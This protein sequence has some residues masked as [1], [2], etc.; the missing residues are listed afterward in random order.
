MDTKEVYTIG[1]VLEQG[2]K[3]LKESNNCSYILDSQLLLSKIINKDKLFI[4]LNRD[5]QIS[6]EEAK[7]YF[8]LIKFRKNKMPIKYILGYTEFMGLN[9]KVKQGVLI[10][11]PDTEIL[12]ENVISVINKNKYMNIADV[13]CGSGAIGVSIAVYCPKTHIDCFDISN[14]ACEV[15]DENASVQ[16]AKHR[17]KVYKS[18][19][20]EVA[21]KNGSMYDVIVS[22]PP[23]IRKDVIPSLMGD[24][25]DYEPHE[26]LDGGE[27]GLYFYRRIA[28]E[29]QGVLNSNGLIAL[30]IGHDQ[31]EAVTEIL[32]N[33]DFHTIECYKDLAGN[34]RVITAYLNNK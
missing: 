34:D 20:L 28:L 26:A 23:Y 11:R 30:E 8:E 17:V 4:M 14:I 2:Y 10:P 18:D 29:S 12:V 6:P 27:D 31:R 32:K 21:I 9:F 3:V 15:T 25:K 22:N 33:S 13:C 24:V 1:K 19:L 7:E 16:E 5:F